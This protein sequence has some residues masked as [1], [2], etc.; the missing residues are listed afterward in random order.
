MFLRHQKLRRAIRYTTWLR[1]AVV[2]LLG[3][4]DLLNEILIHFHS[5]GDLVRAATTCKPF[6]Q[7]TCSRLH[8]FSCPCVLS[9]LLVGSGRRRSA[10]PPSLSIS[11]AACNPFLHASCNRTLLCRLH[12]F[13]CPRVLGSLLVGTGHRRG[14]PPPFLSTSASYASANHDGDIALSFLR[15][16]DG[17][18]VPPIGSNSLTTATASSSS[19]LLTMSASATTPVIMG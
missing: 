18:A 3:E 7:A 10:P 13:C 19:N 4:I 12:P 5:P 1:V 16:A 14:A 6:L 8:P 9:C 2:V 11:A 15:A 17:L